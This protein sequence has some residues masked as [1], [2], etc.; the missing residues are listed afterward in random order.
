MRIP[1]AGHRR[2]YRKKIEICWCWI[3]CCGVQVVLMILETLDSAEQ[4]KSLD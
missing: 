2:S 4:R 1:R 3:H